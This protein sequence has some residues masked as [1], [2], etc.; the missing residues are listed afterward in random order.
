MAGPVGTE[1]PDVALAEVRESLFREPYTFD[2]FQAVRLLARLQPERAPVGRYA[3]PQDEIVRFRANPVLDFPASAIQALEETPDGCPSML[4]NFIGLIG[5]KGVMPNYLTELAATRAR[6]RD[7]TL[8]EFLNIFNHRITSFF[9]Q[10]WQKHHFTAAY[11]RDRTDPLTDCIFALVGLGT[12]GLRHRQPVEDQSWIYYSGLLALIPRSAVALEGLI[13][14]YFNVPVEIDPFMG[15]WRSLD[16]PDMCTLGEE[17][18]E[19]TMLGFGSVVGDEIWDRQSR[20][21][22]KLGPLTAE[23]YREFLPNGAAWQ[24]LRAITKMFC[25]NDLEFEVQLILRREDVPAFELRAPDDGLRLGW[26][27][28]LKSGPEFGR[29]PGDTILLL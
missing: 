6:S 20:V 2:F 17:P 29:N 27:T 3:Q 22:I 28:W 12:P 11:E 15:T 19:S 8:L 9:Y 10:A 4:V 21:R 24:D 16:D 7:N 5:P 13:G 14:D 1:D 23:R 18:S 25:G 26:H